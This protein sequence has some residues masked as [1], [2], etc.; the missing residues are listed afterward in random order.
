[1][2]P[3]VGQGALAIECRA[4]DDATLE[5]ISAINDAAVA[6]EVSA[7]RAFLAVLGGGCD[8]PC[9]ALAVHDG[10]ELVLQAVIASLDGHT[11]LRGNERG[12]DPE[13]LG[14]VLARE[15]LEHGG[16]ELIEQ[17]QR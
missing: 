17:A 1:M 2:I 9:G 12:D 10:D 16:D 8:L 15:L 11:V 5:R 7:E 3:Q 13:L 4:D 6:R 14:R